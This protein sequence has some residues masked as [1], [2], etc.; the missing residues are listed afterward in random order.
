MGWQGNGVD[1]PGPAG[2]PPAAPDSPLIPG[3]TASDVRRRAS[4]TT[5]TKPVL[6]RLRHAA[7]TIMTRLTACGRPA[8]RRVG[9]VVAVTGICLALAGCADEAT[10]YQ[11]AT[12]KRT[13]TAASPTATV[14]SVPIT[15][16]RLPA[17]TPLSLAEMLRP[18]GA[19][20]R[21]YF[22]R[23]GALW[24]VSVD[25]GSAR[26]VFAPGA[27]QR[28]EAFDHS[29]NGERVAIGLT[30]GSDG[31]RTVDLVIL[32][33]AGAPKRTIGDLTGSL[34]VAASAPSS[35]SWSPQGS[36]IL[37]GLEDGGI[38]SV[39]VEG[40]A[41]TLLLAPSTDHQPE[42]ATWSP[43]GEEFAFLD[44]TRSGAHAELF[45][46]SVAATPVAPR[47]VG[48]EADGASIGHFAWMPNGQRLLFTESGGPLGG[49]STDLWEIAPD[50]TGRRLVAPAGI[51]APVAQIT[52]FAVSSDGKSV[53]YAI[54]V[55]SGTAMVF[56]SL[57]IKDMESGKSV[58]VPVPS[59]IT[60]RQMSWTANGLVLEVTDTADS[61]TPRPA[62]STVT[63]LLLVGPDGTVRD[64]LRFAEGPAATPAA[65][66][67]RATP[68]AVPVATP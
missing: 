22:L 45:Q 33:D 44:R 1:W 59:G 10:N 16:S 41:P 64:L 36:P 4:T 42:G 56:D 48:S 58:P 51:A 24:S 34:D 47:P 28:I 26:R 62:G 46:A 49:Q 29:P 2:L 23:D 37:V 67:S 50:G 66:G 12:D 57:W 7:T 25:D 35:V 8:G 13:A 5:W 52:R 6:E 17:A 3:A 38:V 60:I 40:G 20:S 15:S 54:D 32:D 30:S 14:P 65:A 63:R 43:T 19:P 53:A 21:A 18:R 61:A 68:V 55:P 27:G 39:P 31:K 11:F 9:S